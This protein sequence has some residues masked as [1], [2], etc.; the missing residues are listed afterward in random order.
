MAPSSPASDFRRVRH[1]A[2]RSTV[3]RFNAHGRW[4]V[5]R[6]LPKE[7]RNIRTVWWRWEQWVGRGATEEHQDFKDIYRDCYPRDHIPPPGLELTYLEPDDGP[8]I[9]SPELVNDPPHAETNK[10]C[11]NLM[12]EVFGS[13]EVVTADLA[14][15]T[16]TAVRKANWRLLP[17]GRY[18][19]SRL[20]EHIDTA[21]RRHGEKVRRVIWDRQETLKSYGPDELFVGEGGFEEYLAYVFP[22]R[23]M[24]VL[25]SVRRD[26]AIY[27]F[28]LDWQRVSQLTKAEVLSHG[29]HR[30]RII[31]SSGWKTQLARLMALPRAA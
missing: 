6:D 16:P 22:A 14:R 20:H 5:H 19:W 2:R 3:S 26:N 13:C 15:I 30:A 28:G 31:H 18:P 7:P 11:I 24:V 23:N 21:T 10:H 9:V 27:V 8:L 1:R 29:F 12:L 25:E 17:P 4:N